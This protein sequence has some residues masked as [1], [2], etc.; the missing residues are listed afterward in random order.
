MGDS[1]DIRSHRFAAQQWKS[2]RAQRFR[3]SLAIFGIIF[4]ALAVVAIL[5]AAGGSSPLIPCTIDPIYGT[6]MA[7]VTG[8]YV[9]FLWRT[10]AQLTHRLFSYQITMGPNVLRIAMLGMLNSARAHERFAGETSFA[11]VRFW[12]ARLRNRAARLTA[13]V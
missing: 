4:G 7:L 1:D 6:T 2:L 9:W 13:R 3:R 8:G 10:S 11:S 12:D 5:Q